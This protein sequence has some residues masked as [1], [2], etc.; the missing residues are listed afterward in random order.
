MDEA[1]RDREPVQPCSRSGV[2]NC[3][4]TRRYRV[5]PFHR[6][7][8]QYWFAAGIIAIAAAAWL[9]PSW[10]HSRAVRDALAADTLDESDL[11]E[12]SLQTLTPTEAQQ[13][14]DTGRLGHRRALLLNW[15]SSRDRSSSRQLNAE[16]N[17]VGTRWLLE[18]ACDPDL[19]LRTRALGAWREVAS[20]DSTRVL[21]TL[22]EDADSEVRRLGLQTLR[23]RGGTNQIGWVLPRLDDSD[24][25]VVLAADA[26]LRQWT[27][28]D[29]GL[30][31][32][33]VLPNA[34]S[35]STPELADADRE[36]IRKAAVQWHDRFATSDR[37]G[38]F[39]PDPP[40]RLPTTEFVL[41]DLQGRP[42]RSASL[43]GKR[44]LL[45]F[46][47]TWCPACLTEFPVLDALQRRHPE[48]LVVLGISLD[49]TNGT[50]AA[51]GPPNDAA[52]RDL[53]KTVGTITARHRLGFPVLLDP[54][55][56]V[57]RRFNGGE[58]PTQ[59][60][61]DRDGWVRRRFVGGR[62]LDTWEALLADA[63]RPAVS[64]ADGLKPG[65]S[66]GSG[67]AR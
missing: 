54:E 55:R 67:P 24:P 57:G 34:N 31:L 33:R 9:R 15:I 16:W 11:A 1:W 37:A 47:A 35:L 7:R 38:R 20:P 8:L 18:A 25:T 53:R 48:D 42:V 36:A 5:T 17:Q 21:R 52:L 59:V 63:D 46:W 22:L 2:R 58:L 45:N 60:L 14:W 27:G 50:E 65:E 66:V 6:K 4:R 12:S 29:S 19:E 23:L 13:L 32:S 40:R 64:G 30:R 61:L 39:A 43:R 41:E 3:L 44:V 49:S 51:E 10:M 26:V 56:R 62:S 28:I